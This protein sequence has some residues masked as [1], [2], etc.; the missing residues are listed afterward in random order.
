MGDVLLDLNKAIVDGD[1]KGSEQLT[2]GAIEAGMSATEILQKG[3]IPGIRKIGELF[4]EGERF[5]PELIVAGRAM[6]ASIQHLDP[7]FKQ[8]ESAARGKFLIGTVKGDLHDI[9][10]NIVIMMLKGSGWEVTD[11]WIDVPPDEFCKAVADGDYDILGMSALLTTTIGSVT[12]TI[13]AL[14]EAGLRDGIKI[15]IGGA[16]VNQEFTDEVGA[17]AWGQDG[18]DAVVRSEEL[19]GA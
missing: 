18:W 19:L 10:K 11:L 14:S 1:V 3:L 15:I 13:N 6:E 2:V 17:D 8:S 16:V 4:G 7:L 12:D 5:L 9:G